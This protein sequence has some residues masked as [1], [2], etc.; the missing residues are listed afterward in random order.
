MSF[1]TVKTIEEEKTVNNWKITTY[2]TESDYRDKNKEDHRVGNRINNQD[3][4]SH[5]NNEKL[6][7]QSNRHDAIS[8]IKEYIDKNNLNVDPEK[9]IDNV[10]SVSNP[11]D[12]SEDSRANI[13]HSQ[14]IPLIGDNSPSYK[15]IGEVFNAYIILEFSEEIMFVDKHALHERMIFEKLRTS[16][17]IE[18]QT[19]ITPR[20]LSLSE[21]DRSILLDNKENLKNIGFDI[22]DFGGTLI[23][24]EIPAIIAEDDIEVLLTEIANELKIKSYTGSDLLDRF[25]YSIACKAAIKSGKGSSEAEIKNLISDYLKKRDSL[26][27]CPHGRP[28]VF[29]L[30][31]NAIEKQFRRIVG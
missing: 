20:L 22:E 9:L 5:Y 15:L 27:Y 13:N 26:K 8:R 28:I 16:D 10:K 29:L 4:P 31:K 23:I 11:N 19:L 17:F 3:S 24:R 7:I 25:L 12:K 1:S 21:A 30:S 18:I 6:L 14:E 2:K